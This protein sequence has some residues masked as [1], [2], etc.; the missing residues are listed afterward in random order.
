ME[1]SVPDFIVRTALAMHCSL[2]V[3]AKSPTVNIGGHV[4]DVIRRS[5]IPVL[6]TDGSTMRQTTPIEERP[7]K[8]LRSGEITVATDRA[9]GTAPMSIGATSRPGGEP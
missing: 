5:P 1:D 8:T 9:G 4:P 3:C 6:V 2:I 7:A